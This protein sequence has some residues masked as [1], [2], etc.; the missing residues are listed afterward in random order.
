MV[1]KCVPN[2]F[3]FDLTLQIKGRFLMDNQLT[4]V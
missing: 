4:E 3:D 2:A 1:K